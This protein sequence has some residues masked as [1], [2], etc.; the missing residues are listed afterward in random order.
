MPVSRLAIALFIVL[1]GSAVSLRGKLVV[2]S[3]LP[4]QIV[5]DTSVQRKVVWVSSS[6]HSPSGRE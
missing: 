1:G 6:L 3:R 2:L 5:H 4:V